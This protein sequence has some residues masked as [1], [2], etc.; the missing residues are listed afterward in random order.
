MPLIFLCVSALS[1]FSFFCFFSFILLLFLVFELRRLTEDFLSSIIIYA[2][3]RNVHVRIVLA[4]PQ[5]LMCYFYVFSSM[6]ILF[7]LKLPL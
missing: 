1:L 6:Y 4:V 3:I 5:I 7:S 2:L